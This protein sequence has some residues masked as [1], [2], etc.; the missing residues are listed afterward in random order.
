MSYIGNS[1]GVASQRVSTTFTAT[2]G[3]T[4]FT[5][6]SGYT[7]GYCDVYQNGVKLISGDDYT[8]ADGVSVVLGTGAAAGDAVEV[9]AMFPRGLS[10]GYT[11]AEADARYDATG[12]AAALVD[13]LSGVTNATTA[14]ANLGLGNVENKSSATIRGELTSGNVTGALG[15]TPVNKAGDTMTG[16]LSLSAALRAG[17]GNTATVAGTTFSNTLAAATGTNRVV[18][19]DGNGASNASVWWTNGN[20]AYAAFDAGTAGM[21]HWVNDGSNW[22]RQMLVS[23]GNVFFDTTLRTSGVATLVNPGGTS[24]NENIRL[25]RANAGWSSISMASDPNA[26]SGAISGQFTLLVSPTGSGG[27]FAIRHASGTDALQITTSDY[28]LTPQRAAFYARSAV[29]RTDSTIGWS[30]VVYDNA[31]NNTRSCYST[32]NSRFT[33][34]VTGWYQLNA[35]ISFNDMGDTDGTTTFAINGSTNNNRGTISA[36]NTG[37]GGSGFDGRSLSSCMYLNAGDYVEVFRYSTVATTTRESD[38]AGSFSGFLI[39]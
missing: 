18:N 35:Q 39:G 36:P 5:P 8:A 31:L 10:D 1:P 21:E 14:R 17:A 19:F 38:W 23:Y 25:P 26:S 34:P 11:K 30:K 2:A 28:V 13:D 24:Y 32:A 4:T 6:V 7:L 27:S 37:N 3:Q 12:T 9:V 15:Y 16:P 22:Q 29:S 20:R 33:A